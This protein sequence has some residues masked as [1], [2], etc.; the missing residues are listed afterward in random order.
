[1]F[2]HTKFSISNFQFSINFQYFNEL[3]SKHGFYFAK[4]EGITKV[5][6][7]REEPATKR[8]RKN[9]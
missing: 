5:I 6:R 4:S 7:L 9:Y 8:S 3:I 1:M 2:L